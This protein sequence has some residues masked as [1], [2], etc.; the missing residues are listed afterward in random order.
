LRQPIKKN[1]FFFDPANAKV[2]RRCYST[3]RVPE[4]RMGFRVAEV[5]ATPNPNAVK[6]VLDRV[7]AEQP[8][9]FLQADAAKQCPLAEQLFAIAGVSSVLFLGD[10]VTINKHPSAPW[11]PIKRQVK[12]LLS[13]VTEPIQLKNA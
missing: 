6:F 11:P 8:A 7:I 10:F 9:S 1:K 12:L 4:K 3:A 13:K 5:Q 2:I